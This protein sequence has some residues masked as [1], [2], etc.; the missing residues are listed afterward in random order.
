MH[1]LRAR[2]EPL[3]G[4]LPLRP[5]SSGTTGATGEFIDEFVASGSGGLIF[6]II[7]VFGPDDN[8]YVEDV[9]THSILRYDGDERGFHRRLRHRRQ[10]WADRSPRFSVGGRMTSSTLSVTGPVKSFA[11]TGR[12]GISSTSSSPAGSGGLANPVEAAFGRDGNLYV[13][14]E[15]NSSV[16]RYDGTSG[17]F[18]DVF[19]PS[20]SGGLDTPIGMKFGPDDNLY[21]TSLGTASVSAVMT[22]RAGHS[23]MSSYCLGAAASPVPGC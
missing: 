17:A 22:E 20:G 1:G 9:A 2:R 12:T 14:S 13:D 19:V 16:L 11:T 23:S 5:P 21:V 6:P 10:W 3:C 7:L 8:L 18:I 4:Q 15:G